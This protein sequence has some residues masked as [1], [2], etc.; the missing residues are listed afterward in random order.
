[1]ENR[2]IVSDREQ[3]EWYALCPLVI[4]KNTIT[5]GE[6]AAYLSVSMVPCT[7]KAIGKVEI[8]TVFSN[9][10]RVKIDTVGY[11]IRPGQSSDLPCP[12]DAVYAHTTAE[13][14]YGEDGSLLWEKGD[15]APAVLPEQE[16]LWQTD[17]LYAQ[18]RRECEGVVNPVYRPDTVNGGWRCTC[19]HINLDSAESCGACHTGHDWL[20]RHF[21]PDY[22]KERM[23]V[24]EEKKTVSAEKK[25]V[26]FR[27]EKVRDDQRR[28]KLMGGGIAA[29]VVL[30]I[31]LFT[32]IIPSIRYSGAEKALAAGEYDKAAA[33]FTDL[34]S[35]R[36]ANERTAEAMYRK[37]Q[38]MTG[39][40]E[41]NM[42]TTAECPWFVI[43]EDGVLSLRKDKYI[44]SWDHFI[45]P[46]LVDGIIV[47]ELAKSFF[48]NCRDMKTVTL[49]DCI[50]VLGEQTFFNCESLTEVHF[51]SGIQNIGPRA[52]I[53]CYSLTEI[54]IPDT[55]VSIGL[56]AFNSCGD[57]R[58][59][60]LGAGITELPSYI[61]SCCTSL[62]ELVLRA[63]VTKIAAYA[64]SECP[65][66]EVI[67]YAGTK[68]QWDAVVI[69]PEENGILEKVTVITAD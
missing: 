22:L 40:S 66:V 28:M 42:V 69:E 37:A 55:V 13:K 60:T 2:K 65:A 10:R 9:A 61:F 18:I 19:G 58:K 39:L 67:S 49:S 20:I 30:L 48:L 38:A 68:A 41:V 23:S 7:D 27:H 35:F 51:G 25:N 3:K 63:P 6:D 31:L 17:P 12:V 57:L 45:V 33:V 5:K 47:R 24:S 43:S 64:F 53:N 54:T 62:E 14:I 46:D 36:D 50:E 32:F 52:F 4:T 16:I 8:E 34:G 29:A 1:M 59:V 26:N 11:T 56:R 21:D 15:L 44:G